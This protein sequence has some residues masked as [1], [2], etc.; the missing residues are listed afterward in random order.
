[1]Y[2]TIHQYQ[3]RA[4][5]RQ[6]GRGRLAPW[7]RPGAQP[8]LRRGGGQR[9]RALHYR[10]VRRSGSLIAA[11]LLTGPMP[12]NLPRARSHLCSTTPPSTCTAVSPPARTP[13]GS[14][15]PKA[16]PSAPNLPPTVQFA[17]DGLLGH[18]RRHGGDLARPIPPATLRCPSP[19]ATRAPNV[20]LRQFVREPAGRTTVA[21]Q[22]RNIGCLPLAVIELQNEHVNF[23]TVDAVALFQAIPGQPS[24]PDV[25]CLAR[26]L[27]VAAC[28][29]H[30]PA[31][32]VVPGSA[33]VGA[34][35]VAIRAQHL[36]LGNFRVNAR[37]RSHARHKIAYVRDLCRRI[38]V[39]ELED[40]RVCLRTGHTRAWF[41]S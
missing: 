27:H 38:P 9:W 3:L 10:T 12:P 8:R 1:M 39:V 2:A 15:R 32:L 20:A 24:V 4:A 29:L 30:P 14:S 7:I 35:L 17:V 33:E 13:P 28:Q 41:C 34:S 21:D 22:P 16:T 26:I 11:T 36:A 5:P 18:S 37:R 25:G 19:M 40:H 31:K 6:R 23:A